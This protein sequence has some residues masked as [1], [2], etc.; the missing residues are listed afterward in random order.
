MVCGRLDPLAEVAGFDVL[1]NLEIHAGPVEVSTDGC[2]S[3]VRAEMSTERTVM[4]LLYDL[5]LELFRRNED[6][7][8]VLDNDAVSKLKA[9]KLDLLTSSPSSRGIREESELE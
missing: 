1:A 8:V 2:Q 3:L 6:P 7:S 5:K 4:M 9:A